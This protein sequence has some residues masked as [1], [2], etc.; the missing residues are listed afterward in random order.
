MLEYIADIIVAA[1]RAGIDDITGF[2]NGN[3][4]CL[5]GNEILIKG[6]PRSSAEGSFIFVSKLPV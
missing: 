1:I 2:S 3:T 4:V 6:I 5:R